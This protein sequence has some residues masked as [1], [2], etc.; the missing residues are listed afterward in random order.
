[1]E[2]QMQRKYRKR[3]G[4][5]NKHHNVPK[6]RNGANTVEN[7][8]NLDENRHDAFHLL[9]GTRTFVEAARILLRANRMKGGEKWCVQDAEA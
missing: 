1:M 9:F 3:K 5:K 2:V 4:R 6:C 8:I 7:L